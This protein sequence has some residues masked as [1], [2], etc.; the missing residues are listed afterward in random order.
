MAPALSAHLQRRA[1]ATHLSIC[2]TSRHVASVAQP[3]RG[4]A[5]LARAAA[6]VTSEV[7]ST[8]AVPAPRPVRTFGRELPDGSILFS[9]AELLGNSITQPAESS[10]SAQPA[11]AATQPSTSAPP[12][13]P[14][15]A[16]AAP[17]QANSAAR[18]A[19]AAVS[20][21]GIDW[22]V[23]RRRVVVQ[24]ILD[25]AARLNRGPVRKGFRPM[26]STAASGGNQL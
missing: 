15:P 17:K 2:S 24:E 23:R 16:P 14:A 1:Q 12:A 3:V 5:Q 18:P 11:V 4:S 7:T 25:A 9:A 8:E 26:Q 10:I 21:T 19:P 6:V 22:A 13:Q 20:D